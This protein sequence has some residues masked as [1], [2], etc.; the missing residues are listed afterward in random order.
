MVQCRGLV[1]LA[2]PSTTPVT[3]R[4]CGVVSGSR[5]PS[6][7]PRDAG[8]VAALCS[9]GC[10]EPF[11][12]VDGAVSW[13]SLG[14]PMP[15]DYT[16]GALCCIALCFPSCSPPVVCDVLCVVGVLCCFILSLLPCIPCTSGS[17]EPI[18]RGCK[19]L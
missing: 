14:W 1:C 3:Q 13:F 4:W 5:D 18:L 15:F 7:V 11:D 19:A 16:G 6:N 9:L 12:Y 17:L 2:I 10:V 8:G